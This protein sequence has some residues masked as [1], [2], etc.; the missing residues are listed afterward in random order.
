M[1]NVWQDLR[2]GL[3][4]LRLNPGF[5]VVAILSLALGI[6]ANTA[7]FQLIDAVRLRTLPVARPQEL[8]IVRIADRKWA[9]GNFSSRYNQLTNAQWEQIRDHQKAFSRLA[10]WSAEGWDLAVGGEAR[11]AQGIW[12]SGDFFNV[13]E[14]PPVLGRVFSNED[15]V[16]GC[17]SPGAVISYSF[18]QR[19]YGGQA[20]VLGRKI[21]LEGHPFEIIGV[22]APGFYGVDVGRYFD[23]AL[24]LCAERIIHNERPRLDMRHGWWLASIGRLKPGMP[25]GQAS[26]QMNSISTTVFEATVP[27]VYDASAIKH[28][29]EY[30][31]QAVSAATGFSNLRNNYESPLWMLLAIAGSVLLIACAN[32][33]NLMLARASAREREIAVRLALGASRARLIRQLLAESLTLALLGAAFGTLLAAGL[34]RFLVTFLNTQSRQ[35]FVD[36]ALD[37]RVLG[38]TM[39]LA[40]LTCI[41]FGLAPA[42]RATRIPPAAVLKSAGRGMTTSRE[43]FG[44]RR[45]LVVSQVA[46][47]LVLIVGSL[48]FVRTL[49]NLNSVDPGF[50]QAGVLVIDL[51]FT[52]LKLPPERRQPYKK[53]LLE[54]LRAIPG[55]QSAADASIVPVSGNGWNE[56]VMMDGKPDQRNNSQFSRVTPNYFKT[57]EITLLAGRDFDERDTSTSPKVAIVNEAFARKH[58]KGANPI[59]RTFIIDAYV[60]QARPIYTI[61]GYVKDTK[62]YELREEFEPIIFVPAAQD[63]RPD[64]GAQFLIRAA[65]PIFGLLSPIKQAVADA[66]PAISLN[67]HVLGTDIKDGLLRER[68]MATLSG[69]FGFLAAL[70]ATIGL[71]GVI[72]YTVARR[73][74]EIG[75]RMALG[76]QGKNIINMIMR[77]AGLLVVIG[78]VIGTGIAIAVGKTAASLLFGLKPRDP[79]TLIVSVTALAAVAALA[80]FLPAFRASRLDPMRALRDE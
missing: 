63:D 53:D 31:L 76:A 67:F 41:L 66:N 5:A 35:L 34:S 29:M 55:V 62:Y 57:M 19:E 27:P 16:K 59:D 25:M 33:A 10:V 36:L 75:I 23:V 44:L 8:S 3:R 74:N 28:Y 64:D 52:R 1:G 38:F 40:C 58:L 43:R 21:S 45:A 22:T 18:W 72:S 2:Y 7:I 14:V 20:S 6:G 71:Y 73:T 70:L 37:W 15:D 60:G 77:E 4:L 51:D 30:R 17:G 61:V 39:G 9:S 68:L 69:F 56:Q 46:L 50:R 13:L 54:H 42:L 49:R 32:L 26:A 65:V 48:L 12:V 24:P 78:L 11:Y 47:S 79:I 80:S